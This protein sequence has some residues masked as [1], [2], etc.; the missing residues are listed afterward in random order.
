MLVRMVHWRRTA[1]GAVPTRVDFE[2][3]RP[4]AGVQ[5]PFLYTRTWTNN[6]VIMQLKEIRPNAPIDPA[7]FTMPAVPV[8]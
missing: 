6:Q 8:R 5:M 7:R 4:V 2:D 1:V 3:F